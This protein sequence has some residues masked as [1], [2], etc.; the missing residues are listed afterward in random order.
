MESEEAVIVRIPAREM[1]ATFNQSPLL[2][3]KFYCF[4]ATHQAERLRIFTAQTS[5]EVLQAED[6]RAPQSMRQLAAGAANTGN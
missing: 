3:G 1:Y 2:A 4:L 6:S 5:A